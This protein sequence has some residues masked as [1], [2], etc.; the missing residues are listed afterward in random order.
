[1]AP[2]D[3]RDKAHDRAQDRIL[4]IA[5]SSGRTR[6]KA[7]ARRGN[8]VPDVYQDLLSEATAG[9]D[10]AVQQSRPLK[11]RKVKDGRVQNEKQ[12][13]G[14]DS[15]Q[16]TRGDGSSPGSRLNPQTLTDSEASDE[17]DLDWEQ[18]G[19]DVTDTPSKSK[20]IIQ[21]DDELEVSVNVAG[22]YTPRKAAV[23]RRK[24]VTAAERSERLAV[25]KAH[26][27]FLL[28]HVH[29][30]NAWCN[31]GKVQVGSSVYHRQVLY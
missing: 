23:V 3:K 12:P 14:A 4:S 31:S 18:I 28:F 20:D 26:L 15:S 11:R 21:N 13:R 22:T 7:T 17:D 29:V 8:E 24:A 27:L 10:D 25:H 2:R 9:S 5:S 1:M 30:R 16:T 19:L 6:G